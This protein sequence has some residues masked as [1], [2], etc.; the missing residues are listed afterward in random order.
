MEIVDAV[1]ASQEAIVSV[2]DLRVKYGS[3]E[4]LHGVSFDVRRGETVVIMGGRAPARAH[5]CEL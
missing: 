1:S 2:R 3:T 4:I 5:W